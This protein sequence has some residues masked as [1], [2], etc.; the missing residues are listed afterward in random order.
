MSYTETYYC[1]NKILSPVTVQFEA[2]INI[3]QNNDGYYIDGAK[4]SKP[5][6]INVKQDC[7]QIYE[8]NEELANFG[9]TYIVSATG[10]YVKNNIDMGE[11][12]LSAYFDVNPDTGEITSTS[13]M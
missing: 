4:Y 12:T 9:R 5:L 11:I 7:F 3:S 13:N 8:T 10:N 1:T 6:V 2:E